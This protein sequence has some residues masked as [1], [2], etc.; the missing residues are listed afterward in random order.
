MEL[1]EFVLIM[2]LAALLVFMV[3]MIVEKI[4]I[5]IFFRERMP[6]VRIVTAL[7]ISIGGCAIWM[8][9][10][11]HSFSVLVFLFSGA[12]ILWNR[13]WFDHIENEKGN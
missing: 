10:S 12:I 6:A 5:K 13:F 11:G 3:S 2:T 7:A 1:F 4:I 9:G 8:V